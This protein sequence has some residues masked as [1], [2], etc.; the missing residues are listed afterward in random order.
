MLK[1]TNKPAL[2][3][4]FEIDKA[5]GATLCTKYAAWVKEQT[6]ARL[7]EI[8]AKTIEA[9]LTDVPALIAE[10]SEVIDAGTAAIVQAVT[11]SKASIAKTI[12][13]QELKNPAGLVRKTCIIRFMAEAG[14]TKPGANTYYQN[15]RDKFG[16]A[17]HKA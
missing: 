15:L 7:V 11:V 5:E 12:F 3:A 17:V 8:Q 13:E 9:S 6:D 1:I 4:Q 14:L 16:L 2:L 10:T